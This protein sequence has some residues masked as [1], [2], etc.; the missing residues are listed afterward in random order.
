VNLI[1]ITETSFF[2]DPPQLRLLQDVI[3]PSLLVDRSRT[4]IRIWSA[5]C[6][7]G[8]EAYSIAIVLWE[9]GLLPSHPQ[10]TF[11]IVGTDVNTRVLEAARRG[12]YA[13]RAVRHMEPKLL[14]RHFRRDGTQYTI[15]DALK[16]CV[17]FEYGNLWHTP[18]P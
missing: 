15:N 12:V 17:Q 3:L 9:T 2:R 11:E 13:K 14:Y 8:E 1:S 10:F 6:S 4:T 5:G 7:S 18:M 16:A